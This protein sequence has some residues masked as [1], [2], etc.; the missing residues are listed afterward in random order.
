MTAVVPLWVPVAT[1]LPEWVVRWAASF[2][3]ITAAR[4]EKRLQIKSWLQSAYIGSQLM[5]TCRIPGAV[6]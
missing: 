1:A 5:I 3:H 6:S 2:S 4:R